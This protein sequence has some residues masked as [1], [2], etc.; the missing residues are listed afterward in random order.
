MKTHQFL[1]HIDFWKQVF[2]AATAAGVL[3]PE[4]RAQAA[5]KA[6]ELLCERLDKKRQLSA[7]HS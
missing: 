1:E 2:V 4:G 3:S 6:V 7:I 5:D